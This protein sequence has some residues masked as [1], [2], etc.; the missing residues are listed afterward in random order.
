MRLAFLLQQHC[1][2][3][4]LMQLDPPAQGTSSSSLLSRLSKRPFSSDAPSASTSAA[5]A[6]RPAKQPRLNEPSGSG[7]R[8]P[9]GESRAPTTS[10]GFGFRNQ[11]SSRGS[12]GGAEPSRGFKRPRAR[13]L[14]E[15]EGPLRD[16]A[17]AK[18]LCDQSL[19][20]Q[21]KAS[22]VDNPKSTITNFAVT[23]CDGKPTYS[24]QNG[25][26]PGHLE[27]VWR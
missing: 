9:R 15:L 17:Y 8:R 1:R 6:M 2:R 3:R 10:S 7:S 14:P 26:V 5:A 16:E 27:S 22:Y 21:L 4:L 11:G 24:T 23:M 13:G 25:Y 18:S 12:R 19:M 20:S